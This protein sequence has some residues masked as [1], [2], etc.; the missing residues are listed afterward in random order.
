M[1]NTPAINNLALLVGRIMISA[2]FIKAGYDKIGGYA[3]VQKYMD[4][5]GVPGILL[6]LVLLTEIGCGLMLIVGFKTR[7][8][9]FLLA[10]F[11]LVSALIF[12]NK[13]GDMTQYLYFTKNIAI[14]GGL[15]ALMVAGAGAWSVDGKRG[16]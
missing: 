13:I 9:A 4:A 16:E 7:I 1:F 3:G 8:A 14:T 12:H 15:L 2:M 11:T 6:P 5:F 10:G